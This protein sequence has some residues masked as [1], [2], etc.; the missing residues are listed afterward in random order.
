MRSDAVAALGSW[1]VKAALASGTLV[2]LW[3][4]VLV[5]G[6]R[7]LELLTRAA[8]ALLT[9]GPDAVLCG[10]TAARLHGCKAANTSPIHVLMRYERRMQARAELRIHRGWFS[11]DDVTEIEGLSVLALDKTIADLLC[12]RDRREALACA[13]QAVALHPESQRAMFIAAVG[14]RLDQRR[15]RRGTRQALDLLRLIDGR[16]ESPP[17]SWLR[18]LVVE[19]GFPPPA[20]QY[21]IV[22]RDGALVYR[23]DLAWPEFRIA[24]EYDGYEAHIGRQVQDAARDADLARRG[25]LTV[26]ATVDDLRNSR[27]LLDELAR[28][29]RERHVPL[30]GLR[31]PVAG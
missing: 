30:T 19:A 31:L 3:P 16:A 24:L 23:L 4:R 10:L 13:D 22:D 5:D 15:D 25:W 26:R 20:V 1:R 12:S 27:R 28:V 7:Q 11:D 8:A 18:L 21:S 17:E 9:V 2:A 6:P 29:F 14:L